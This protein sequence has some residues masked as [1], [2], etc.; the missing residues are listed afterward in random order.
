MDQNQVQNFSVDPA[1]NVIAV[2]YRETLTTPASS[3]AACTAGQFT[4]DANFQ[5]LTLI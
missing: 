3:S 5:F 4:D 1:G 2:K